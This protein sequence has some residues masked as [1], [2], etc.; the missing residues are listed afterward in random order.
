MLAKQLIANLDD[1]NTNYNN[2]MDQ[3]NKE[4]LNYESPFAVKQTTADGNLS[5]LDFANSYMSLKQRS[6]MTIEYY[7][8]DSSTN[9][10]KS[11]TVTL[12]INPERL[13]I[14]NQKII[15]KATT[16]EGIFYHH[17]GD[18]DA[19]MSLSGTTGLSGMAG[20]KQL[21]EIYFASGT[22]LRYN[23]FLPTTVYGDVSEFN[24]LDYSDP[25]SVISKVSNSNYNSSTIT[26]IQN[27]LLD[28]R[29]EDII[30]SNRLYDS[31]SYL[32]TYKSNSELRNFLKYDL[33]NVYNDVENTNK[34]SYKHYREYYNLLLD[35]LDSV[36]TDVDN[37]V[38]VNIAYELS[39]QK[40]YSNLENKD[41]NNAI[42]NTETNMLASMTDF[43]KARNNALKEYLNKIQEFN[44]RDKEIRN[45]LKG[46]FINLTDELTDEWLPRKITIYFQS[47]AYIGHFESFNYNRDAKT[48][49]ITYDMKFVITKQYQFCDDDGEHAL[50]NTN[51]NALKPFKGTN[52]YKIKEFKGTNVYEIKE[53]K[54]SDKDIYVVQQGDTLDSIAN[55]FYGDPNY[56]PEIYADNLPKIE[57]PSCIYPGQ[58]FK[59]SKLNNDYLRWVVIQNDTIMT[60]AKRFYGDPYKWKRIYE[61]NPKE[62]PDPSYLKPGTILKIPI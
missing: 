43:E 10:A 46:G 9:K 2:W 51:A 30:D 44:R 12:Y 58:K 38:K 23:N 34:K 26:D 4:A 3:I 57:Y 28:S 40:L 54:K 7:N 18:G 24:V 32:E 47:R 17:W 31:V 6:P 37:D 36:M 48:N 55:K 35:E 16:R 52:T 50:A 39:L 22:L 21:E 59:I 49:L 27:K 53:F 42:S 29:K 19:V 5:A 25:I 61:A 14:S 13:S 62:I 20:I 8:I 41:F 56:W 60:V 11:K 33:K 15:A 1:V 45:L